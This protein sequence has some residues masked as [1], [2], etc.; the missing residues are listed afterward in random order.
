[1]SSVA[2]LLDEQGPLAKC[3]PGFAPREEQQRMAEATAAAIAGEEKLIVEAGTGTGKTF[4]YLIAALRAGGKIL[5]STGTRHLQDQLYSRDLPTV[6]DAL[7]VA[8]KTALL[9][10]RANYLCR[11]RLEVAGGEGRA[12]RDRQ[13]HDLETI[14]AWAGRTGSGDIAGLG[15]VPED[16]PLWPRVTSTAENCLGQECEYYQDCFVVKARRSAMEADVVVINH[17]LLFAD[18]VLKEEG[19]GELLPGADAFIIDEAHQL[20][21]VASVFFGSTLSSFQFG[22]LA[23]DIQVEYLREAGDIRE[24]PDAAMQLDGLVRR[25]RLALGRTDRR[26]AWSEVAAERKVRDVV[27]QLSASLQRLTEL[28]GQVAGRGKGLDNCWQRAVR[29][30]ESFRILQE[31]AGGDY[32]HWFESRHSAFRL[33]MTPLNVAPAFKGCLETLS[34]AWIFTSATLAVGKSFRHFASRLGLEDA[35]TLKL[36]SPFDYRGN[37]LLYLPADMPPP[38]E[39]RHTDAVV[40]C[41]REVL[42]ASR[43]RAFILFTSHTALQA[44]A[45]RLRDSV[46]FPLLV[47]GSA[48]RQELLER[49]RRSGNAVLLGTSSFWEGVDVRGEALSCVII[50]KLP[51]SSPGDPVLQARIEALRGQGLN[52]FVEYQLPNAVINLKQGIGRLIRDRGDRGVL[53]LCDPRLRTRSYGRVFLGSLPDMPQTSRIDTVHEFFAGLEA[54]EAGSSVQHH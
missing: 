53:V 13:L 12:L 8:M 6:R 39:S 25:L 37:A 46:E 7:G 42:E 9:K 45:S 48:P 26:A 4:A 5:V 41:A 40:D 11:H 51:F 22:D 30:Q 31:P 14:R 43:G 17:H 2:A 15:T 21:D 20:P 16:S 29:L 10:G 24:L 49:F 50:D 38:N 19:F 1:M 35:K 54:A 32:I 47:Q 23:R 34:G 52:P 28:L 18:M 33:N 27:Q 3:V 44:A 36:D